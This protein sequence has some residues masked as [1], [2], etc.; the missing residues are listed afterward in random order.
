LTLP[1]VTTNSFR[2]ENS[3]YLYSDS[4]MNWCNRW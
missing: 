4:R 2:Q 1:V 3:S